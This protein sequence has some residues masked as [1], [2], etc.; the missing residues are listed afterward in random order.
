MTLVDVLHFWDCF[1]YV[2]KNHRFACL[3]PGSEHFLQYVT[4][5]AWHNK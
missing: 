5:V 4:Y 2:I 3:A 1:A